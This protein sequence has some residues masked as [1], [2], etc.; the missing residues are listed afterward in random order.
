MLAVLNVGEGSLGEGLFAL[1]NRVEAGEAALV[2]LLKHARRSPTNPE[3]LAGLVVACRFCGLLEASVEADRRARRLDPSV[4]TS[5]AFTHWMRG[6]YAEAMRAD[7]EDM[8]W[9]HH[10]SLPMLGRID[11]AIASCRQSEERTP[12]K[13]ELDMLVSTRAALEK[14]VETCVAAV[15]RVFQSNFHD[16]EGLYFEARN[17][18]YVGEL[19]LGL[20]ILDRVVSRGLSCGEK[21]VTD[22]W[23]EP[24][25]ADGRLDPLVD[26]ARA[27][28]SEAVRCYREGGGEPL[29][30]SLG[31]VFSD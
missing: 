26:I 28:R 25:R 23:L 6:D 14:D 18:V 19:D 1:N 24:L 4:A 30:G 27:G 7:D 20:E 22:P 21:L 16:P 17:A 29:L 15:R 2:R 5:V 31:T 11:E 9:V 8:R 10:Y 13:I 12:R 3:L